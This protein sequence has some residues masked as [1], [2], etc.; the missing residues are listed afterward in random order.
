MGAA[1]FCPGCCAGLCGHSPC[2]LAARINLRF[3]FQSILFVPMH[4]ISVTLAIDSVIGVIYMKQRSQL[5]LQLCNTLILLNVTMMY[6]NKCLQKN[7]L[8]FLLTW[9][10]FGQLCALLWLLKKYRCSQK[11]PVEVIFIMSWIS[12]YEFLRKIAVTRL[13]PVQL[14]QEQ[15]RHPV[16]HS[17][18]SFVDKLSTFPFFIEKEARVVLF[19]IQYK[20]VV[21]ILFL[22]AGLVFSLDSPAPS[23]TENR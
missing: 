16:V 22:L 3:S 17:H 6:L 4:R 1:S 20:M 21:D 19:Q 15:L 18:Q 5:R 23:N 14:E 10:H 11:Q 8:L 7:F 2:L 12:W 9:S 13:E